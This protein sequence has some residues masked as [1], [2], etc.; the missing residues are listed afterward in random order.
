MIMR[1]AR[2]LAALAISLMAGGL[3]AQAQSVSDPGFKPGGSLKLLE[4]LTGKTQI[5][6][7]VVHSGGI[8]PLG[9]VSQRQIRGWLE[10]SGIVLSDQ[11]RM[12]GPGANLARRGELPW[13]VAII[14]AGF[15]EPTRKL[16]CGGVLIDARTVVTAA[17]C[18]DNNTLP[19]QI[20]II[21]GTT[22]YILGGYR[23]GVKTIAV[24]PGWDPDTKQHDIAVLK[25]R[26]DASSRPIQLPAD[27]EPIRAGNRVVV[28]GWGATGEQGSVSP[29][30]LKAE[31]PVVDH[32]VCNAPESYAGRVK[33]GM[34]CA[35]DGQT[36]SCQGDSG[37]PSAV[38]SPGAAPRLVGL[39][40]WG[41][42]CGRP[43]KYGVYTHVGTYLD[44]L[45]A[46]RR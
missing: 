37:G 45:A 25:L 27:G 30:L 11:P 5:L 40:S 13:Q 39:V 21:E 7:P 18:V 31:L 3:D 22:R 8:N 12:V 35:G 9:M 17:H 36:D 6:Q 23:I 26:R 28:S 41:D 19:E 10:G 20:E 32:A 42:G 24:H 4:G 2:V 34:F 33:A 44:W 16:H 46:S 15:P 43:L 1:V 38:I 29:D 14:Y